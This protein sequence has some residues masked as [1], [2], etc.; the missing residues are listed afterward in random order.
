MNIARHNHHEHH[1]GHA[2]PKLGKLR[3][4]CDF[5][6]LS[7]VKCDRG[8]PQCL[9]CIRNEVTCHYSQTRRSGKARR[10]Y[11]TSGP[12]START[13]AGSQE[14]Q[15]QSGTEEGAEASP[16]LGHA[17]TQSHSLVHD[18]ANTSSTSCPSDFLKQLPPALFENTSLM[19]GMHLK[20]TFFF[21][22]CLF[23]DDYNRPSPSLE[24]PTGMPF[25]NE[26]SEHP[27]RSPIQWDTENRNQRHNDHYTPLSLDLGGGGT[28]S[29]MSKDT[30]SHASTF[31]RPESEDCMRRALSALNGLHVPA[32]CKVNGEHAGCNEH[33]PPRSLDAT[34]I[35]NRIAMDKIRLVL[36]C[37]CSKTSNIFLL[38][39][40]ATQQ[41]LDS[42]CTLT[43]MQLFLLSSSVV[44]KEP[45]DVAG[46]SSRE[47]EASL[48]EDVPVAIGSYVVDGEAK[49]R[50]ILQVLQAET[51]VLGGLIDSLVS[52]STQTAPKETAGNVC[53]AFIDSLQALYRE[54]MQ[55]LYL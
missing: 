3:S 52:L 42:Y 9:R 10:I 15:Q 26:F 18:V 54:T 35:S 8:Q 5:C 24:A 43:K 34:L 48:S 39:A 49:S 31:I 47:A 16:S 38:V 25:P 28:S 20:P 1:Q 21:F 27:R 6:A 29:C 33:S 22:F 53:G 7:K 19:Y 44:G 50:A 51:K 41:V 11:S 45:V 2:Q 30:T 55:S 17:M 46:V 12:S 23:S 32:E 36:S 4:S 13:C 40:F 14:E 37:S